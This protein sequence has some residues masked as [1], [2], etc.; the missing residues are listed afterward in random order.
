MKDHSDRGLGIWFRGQIEDA[1]IAV[2]MANLEMAR[3]VDTPEMRL[4]RLGY[5]AAILAVAAFFGIHYAAKT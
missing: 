3:H 5:E 4:Y 2:D 1:L